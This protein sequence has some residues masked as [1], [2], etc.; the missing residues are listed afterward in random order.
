MQTQ[1]R[2]RG[3]YTA[4]LVGA[5]VP[6]LVVLLVPGAALLQR[7]SFSA[8][9]HH[10]QDRNTLEA[11]RLS[12]ITSTITTFLVILAGTPLAYVL[13]RRS[14]SGVRVLETIVDLPTVF[15]PAVA[16]VA[17]L[18][19]FGRKGLVGGWLADMGIEIV[20]TPVAVVIAQ[21]FVAGPFYIRTAAVG[22][23]AVP[24]E[25]MEAATLDGADWIAQLRHVTL[26][27]AWRAIVSGA[28]LCWA[29]AVG[30][31]GATMIFAGNMPGRTQTMTLAVYIG[32]ET[33]LDQALVLAVILLALS[34]LVLLFTRTW[35]ARLDKS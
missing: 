4:L 32:F 29:R 13:A 27:L 16:G 20:F 2:L 5:C 14:G 23:A 1:S 15:P 10:L 8:F 24:R 17:L 12:A 3:L 34:F 31:F 19:A 21:I 18:L 30:E 26:P 25:T 28:V 11:I 6:L 9:L 7:F 22:L 33:D 35:L